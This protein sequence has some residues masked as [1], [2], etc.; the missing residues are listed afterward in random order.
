MR[1]V[2]TQISIVNVFEEL[3]YFEQSSNNEI[4]ELYNKIQDIAKLFD[5]EDF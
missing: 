3:S 4:K 5:N 2:M 1:K